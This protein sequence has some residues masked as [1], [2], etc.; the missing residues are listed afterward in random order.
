M[1]HINIDTDNPVDKLVDHLIAATGAFCATRSLTAD[2]IG[3]AIGQLAAAGAD[4]L[5]SCPG[6]RRKYI[7]E[8]AHHIGELA[9]EL[10]DDEPAV[11]AGL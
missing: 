9:E 4:L 7:E 5:S 2:E 3:C 1:T 8:V 6:C 10:S 11:H